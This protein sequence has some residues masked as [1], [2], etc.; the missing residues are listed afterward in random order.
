MYDNTDDAPDFSYHIQAS[1]L[2]EAGGLR[3][4]AY[5]EIFKNQA[6]P[7]GGT[8]EFGVQAAGVAFATYYDMIVPG[9]AGL[10]STSVNMSL[11]GSL[12]TNPFLPQHGP[13]SA[14]SS[15]QVVFFV[16]G[17]NIGGGM[18]TLS[19]YYGSSP[20]LS[21][22]GILASWNPLTGDITSPSFM[23]EANV[24][25]TMQI[26]LQADAGA[27]GYMQDSFILGGN[28]DFGSTLTF[29][30]TG[31]VFNLPAGYTADSP[32]AGIVNNQ[33]IAP[34]PTSLALAAT[35]AVLGGRVRRRR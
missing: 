31:P 26:Q 20:G 4:H 11:H 30:T 13:N 23:V 22:T 19:S 35:C 17:N 12:V 18:Q 5:G 16:N 3:A 27:S 6:W 21:S 25:F 34:E 29:P 8:Y 24:P 10:V 33:Y 1:S 2:A 9:S 32:D 14:N 15:V 28:A 7:T